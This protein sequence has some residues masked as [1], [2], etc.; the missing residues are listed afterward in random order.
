MQ[1]HLGAGEFDDA[2]LSSLAAACCTAGQMAVLT[3]KRAVAVGTTTGTTGTTTVMRMVTRTVTTVMVTPTVT[4]VVCA[5]PT[6]LGIATYENRW[7]WLLEFGYQSFRVLRTLLGLCVTWS[8]AP[9]LMLV[10]H[11]HGAAIGNGHL[12][13]LWNWTM[14]HLGFRRW[15]HSPQW[16]E[17]AKIGKPRTHQESKVGQISIPTIADTYESAQGANDSEAT[18]TII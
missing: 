13:R 10:L 11:Q 7:F 18:P 1:S 3:L 2:Y 9:F 8:V 17:T 16:T 12:L 4:R 14:L 5:K 15:I 6:I